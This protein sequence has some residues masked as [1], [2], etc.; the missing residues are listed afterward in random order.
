MLK[1]L[2]RQTEQR[3]ESAAELAEDLRRFLHHQPVRARRTSRLRQWA[4][5]VQ[6]HR[7][8]AVALAASLL[9]LIALSVVG[10]LVAH[11]YA[12]LAAT[13]QQVRRNV[14]V[15]ERHTDDDR[16]VLEDTPGIDPVHERLLNDTLVRNERL[17]RQ[18]KLAPEDRYDIAKGSVSLAWVMD[19]RF[20]P[21]TAQRLCRS[22]VEALE[23]QLREEPANDQLQYDL[24]NG[25]LMLGTSQ[26][27][28][29]PL[30]RAVELMKDLVTRYPKQ[31]QYVQQLNWCDLFLIATTG[32]TATSLEDIRSNC[33]VWQSLRQQYPKTVNTASAG[34]VH[35][36]C[37]AEHS[38]SR[39]LSTM[40]R[41]LSWRPNGRSRPSTTVSG[42]KRVTASH[43]QKGCGILERC[44]YVADA[45]SKRKDSVVR[46]LLNC[47][48]SGGSHAVT[49]AILP[50]ELAGKIGGILIARRR[51]EQAE[52]A[53]REALLHA[54]DSATVNPLHRAEVAECHFRLGQLLYDTGR[55]EEARQQFLRAIELARASER[56][57]DELLSRFLVSCPDD[58]LRDLA[59]ALVHAER[60]HRPEC[61]LSW[62]QLA[63]AQY[64]TGKNDDAISSI[65]ETMRCQNG[66]EA[67]DHFL[68]AMALFRLG[69][70]SAAAKSYEKGVTLMDSPGQVPVGHLKRIYDEADALLSNTT[71]P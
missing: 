57:R 5:W 16:V 17:L 41:G 40:R 9:T 44:T 39:R 56:R 46:R 32:L 68:L 20:D 15:A 38:W 26:A 69:D 24:A 66:G 4:H 34:L 61:G 8:T 3:Y 54:N 19:L 36:N 59:Q 13:E 2:A 67:F 47:S 25:Y 10:P 31:P 51:L 21:K 55:N 62:R 27:E 49:G 28:T 35:I 22:A 18:P 29:E 71:V 23:T 58:S 42:G 48:R 14:G 7:L 11:R 1:A 70:S 65:R 33:Q 43:A 53:L 60:T 37:W 64:R 50:G 63:L 30:E 45:P 52:S 12:R 6:R